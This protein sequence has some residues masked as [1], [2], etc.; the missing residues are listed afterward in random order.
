MPSFTATVVSP[1][2]SSA[3]PSSQ[4]TLSPVTSSTGTPHVPQSAA[5]IPVSPTSVP[6][7]Q[8][9]C[10]SWPDTVWLSTPFGAPFMACMPTKSAASQPDSRN[11]VYSVQCCWT[12]NSQSA[13][14]SSGISELNDH[15]PPAPWQSITTISVAPAAFAPR[16]AALISSV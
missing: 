8:R 15:P 11:A 6:L 9:F 5:L 16:T 3:V 2:P 12:T 14:S 10:H 1:S 13:S 4:V 7:N